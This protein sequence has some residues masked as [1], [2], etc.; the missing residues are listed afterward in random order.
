MPGITVTSQI[1]SVTGRE[2]GQKSTDGAANTHLNGGTT[3]YGPHPATYALASAGVGVNTGDILFGPTN[4]TNYDEHVIHCTVGTVVIEASVDGITFAAN[5][6]AQD[7]SATAATTYITSVT[8]GK[9][10]KLTGKFNSVRVKQSGA[11]A[12]TANMLSYKR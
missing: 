6:A 12:A 2:V 4:M 10:V 8:V 11:P 7:L 9:I 5:I 1:D 3:D